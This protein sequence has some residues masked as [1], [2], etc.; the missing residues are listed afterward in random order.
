MRPLPEARASFGPTVRPVESRSALVVSHHLGGFLRIGSAGLLR[1]AA[2]PGVRR[3]LRCRPVASRRLGRA[4]RSPRRGFSLRRVPLVSSRFCIAASVAFLSFASVLRFRSCP[5]A[6]AASLP[7]KRG[8]GLG[9]PGGRSHRASSR[10]AGAEA[11]ASGGRSRRPPTAEAIGFEGVP[12][13][14][15]RGGL[16]DSRG[17]KLSRALPEGVGVIHRGGER[18]TGPRSGRLR[19]FNRGG[20]DGDRRSGA[21][22]R[23]TVPGSSGCSDPPKRT[24][25]SRRRAREEEVR[26]LL[27]EAGG[28]VPSCAP[29]FVEPSALPVARFR[30]QQPS[31]GAADFK[32]LLR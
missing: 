22:N 17:P 6:R 7:K 5:V 27:A 2:G 26:G 12:R 32:A 31:G 3:V 10:C 24:P 19:Y 11:S 13:A 14:G 29:E 20:S 25:T 18:L 9:P 28:S 1:P 16:R 21:S 4:V 15:H 30:G 23:R 8:E